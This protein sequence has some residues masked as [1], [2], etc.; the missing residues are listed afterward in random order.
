MSDLLDFFSKVLEFLFSD[1][2]TR[3]ESLVLFYKEVLGLMKGF[4]LLS[5]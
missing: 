4:H 2:E 3:E 1:T 5:N